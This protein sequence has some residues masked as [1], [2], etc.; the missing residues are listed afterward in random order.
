MPF[1][2]ENKEVNIDIYEIGNRSFVDEPSEF[3]IQV[4]HQHNATINP[5]NLDV[6]YLKPIN[7][8]STLY[9][10]TLSQ[11]A[12]KMPVNAAQSND[13]SGGGTGPNISL[14]VGIVIGVAVFAL[15]IVA[16]VTTIILK[17]RAK[18]KRKTTATEETEFQYF[19]YNNHAFREVVGG[20]LPVDQISKKY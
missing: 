1:L 12:P 2:S 13:E 18:R 16:A 11:V 10:S 5:I 17:R 7:N 3:T 19:S 15:V 20:T 14:Y 6:G 9:R 4:L 8:R